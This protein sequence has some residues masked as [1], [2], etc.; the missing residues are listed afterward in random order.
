MSLY[1]QLWI[2]I[3]L[4]MLVV[5]GITFVINGASSSRYLEQQLSLKNND[6]ANALA[7]SLSQDELDPVIA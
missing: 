5:F 7:L 2:A 4:L 3:A 1:K 6:D